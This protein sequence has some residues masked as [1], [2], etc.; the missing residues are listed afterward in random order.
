M[1]PITVPVIAVSAA[2]LW[3]EI[4]AAEI[5]FDTI[6]GDRRVADGGSQQ[7][8]VDDVAGDEM[9]R[10][11][12]MLEKLVRVHQVTLVTEFLDAGEIA[13]LADRRDDQVDDQPDTTQPQGAEDR[14]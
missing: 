8:R 2:A 13:A 4:G 9:S 11:I 14:T 12:R 1:A 7:M 3:A 6:R 5:T 10:T